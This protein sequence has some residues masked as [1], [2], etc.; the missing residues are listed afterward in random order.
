MDSTL[1]NP[2]TTLYIGNIDPNV[3]KALL[4][5]LFI[6]VSPISKI[7]YPRDKILDTHQGYAFI[8]FFTKEDADYVVKVMNNTVQLYNRTLK[9]RRANSSTAASQ[10]SKHVEIGAKLF[11]KNL[12]DLVDVAALAK[13]FGKFGPFS[14]QPEIFHVKQAD[15]KCAYIYYTT[16]DDSDQALAKL[17][18]QI[19]FNRSISVDYA[20]KDEKGNEKHGDE[21]ERLL[22]KEAKKHGVTLA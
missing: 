1:N 19:V 3:T 6:Q 20:F 8:E 17:N 16:F 11:V 14:K 4:Y 21:V 10:P 22:D 7:R 5:E 2:E 13:I 12:D 15:Y 18:N 9:V